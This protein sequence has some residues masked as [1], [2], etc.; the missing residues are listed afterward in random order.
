MNAMSELEAGLHS[1]SGCVASSFDRGKT[2]KRQYQQ[3]DYCIDEDTYG[4][5]RAGHPLLDRLGRN[6]VQV[7]DLTSDN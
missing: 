5:S 1:V 4:S 3:Y 6:L 7:D 2:L